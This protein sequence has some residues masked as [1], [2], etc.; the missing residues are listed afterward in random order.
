MAGAPGPPT[1]RAPDSTGSVVASNWPL[2][3]RSSSSLTTGSLGPPPPPPPAPPPPPPPPAPPP[4]PPPPLL[5]PVT[6]AT[7]AGPPPPPPPPLLLP[8]TC[9]TAAGRAAAAGGAPARPT[10]SCTAAARA[11][12]VASSTFESINQQSGGRD[13]Q[14]AATHARHA[15]KH[16]PSQS[17]AVSVLLL[18]SAATNA[19]PPPSPTL[20]PARPAHDNASPSQSLQRPP[21]THRP[22]SAT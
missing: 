3:Y 11:A 22:S 1:G 16:A 4:P 7:S 13:G 20:L 14:G 9:A 8:V 5:L 21:A 19:R 2:P 17:S 18:R 12:R 15:R 10:F 6:R